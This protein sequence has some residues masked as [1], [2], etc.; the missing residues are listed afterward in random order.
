MISNKGFRNEFSNQ[1]ADRLNTNFT[2]ERVN[3][4]NRFNKAGIS[5]GNG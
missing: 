5:S 1:Y 3:A 2:S 4:D